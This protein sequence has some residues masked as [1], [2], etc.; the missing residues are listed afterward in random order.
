MPRLHFHLFCVLISTIHS[1]DIDI[2]LMAIYWYFS[3]TYLAECNYQQRGADRCYVGRRIPPF[4][5]QGEELLR[6]PL[7]ESN[8]T[9]RSSNTKRFEPPNSKME[10]NNQWRCAIPTEE[11]LH[12][13]ADLCDDKR[14][15]PPPSR[16]RVKLGRGTH[17][18]ASELPAVRHNHH[19]S[20]GYSHSLSMA[21]WAQQLILQEK[22]DLC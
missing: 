22:A 7:T 12:K 20:F 17:G 14:S 10:G 15:V 18:D 16:T 4:V 5:N 6:A 8:G 3:I 2:N 13:R 21:L 9:R 19:L 11:R 1:F